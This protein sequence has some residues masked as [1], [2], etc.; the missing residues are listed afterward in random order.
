MDSRKQIKKS[1]LSTFKKHYLSFVL[2][3]MIAGFLGVDYSGTISYLQTV[4]QIN[5]ESISSE[6]NELQNQFVEE[7]DD[8]RFTTVLE[9]LMEGQ[10]KNA[11]K[12]SDEIKEEEKKKNFNY[13]GFE[14]GH[15]RGV[16]AGIVNAVTSGS[17]L[18]MAFA[19][20]SSMFGSDNIATIGVILIDMMISIFISK[21]IFTTYRV[22]MRRAMLESRTYERVPFSRC[23]YLFKTH[24]FIKSALSMI[25]VDFLSFLWWFTIVGGIIKYFSYFLV[26]YIVAENPDISP[27]EAIKLSKRMMKGHKWEC[28]V[29]LISF[30]GWSVLGLLTFGLLNIFFVNPYKE[31]AFCEYYAQLRGLSQKNGIEKAELMNDKYLYEKPS[32][33]E[34]ESAYSD[35]IELMN[36]P[37]PQV[38]QRTGISKFF[39][40]VFGV[41]LVY[42]ESE[43]SYSELKEREAKIASYKYALEGKTYPT[44]LFT[45]PTKNRKKTVEYLHYMRHYSVISLILIFFVFCI[46]GW[47]WEVSFHMM[48]EGG[49]VNRGTMHGPWLPI[50]GGGIVMIL[51]LLNKFRKHLAVEFIMTV[52]LCGF[53][54]YF[55]S[56]IL[57]ATHD[58][59][60]WWDYS[61]YFINLN[62]R[63]SAE[64]LLL[65]GVGGV[66]IVYF[67]APLL[68]NIFRKMSLKFAVP[69]CAVLIIAFSIDLAYSMVNPNMSQDILDYK[70]LHSSQSATPDTPDSEKTSV[71][72]K[73]E[74][75]S[76]FTTAGDTVFVFSNSYYN[77]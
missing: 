61:G 51:V 68:D 50:Y 5:V 23:L 77:A 32:K 48:V 64:G 15:S 46:G 35:I 30:A 26:P 21:F 54:E 67:A 66:V 69:I 33:S 36:S 42:D 56:V 57:E 12:T 71:S 1:A 2:V 14:I 10:Y 37:E 7:H 53:V 59:Q 41:V 43:R 19:S 27:C 75:T 9:K 11:K 13:H 8:F 62:G 31:S 47:V 18:V 3:I 58:G 60:M 63:I 17:I 45:I 44:K 34:V 20:I 55:T 52:V 40:D 38:K 22:I 6:V 76:E 29:L 73:P 70:N 74:L 24:K 28:F 25:L 65:F 49:F 39:A 16:L 4:A 72:T